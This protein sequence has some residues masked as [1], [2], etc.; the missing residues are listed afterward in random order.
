[1]IISNLQRA[2]TGAVNHAE[3]VVGMPITL[4]FVSCSIGMVMTAASPEAHSAVFNKPDRPGLPSHKRWH[5]EWLAHFKAI[6]T[7]ALVE[8]A[9]KPQRPLA[10][11]EA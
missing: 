2:L 11:P 7:V 9:F 6:K 1:M 10:S 4:C 8:R 5:A 3:G